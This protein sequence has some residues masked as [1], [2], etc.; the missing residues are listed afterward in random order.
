LPPHK[1]QPGEAEGEEEVAARTM[2]NRVV[3][4]DTYPAQ[5]NSLRIFSYFLHTNS[6]QQME[7]G[8]GFTYICV[9]PAATQPPSLQK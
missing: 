5:K 1:A 6:L 9:A 8:P 4:Y 2:L 3:Y 7:L